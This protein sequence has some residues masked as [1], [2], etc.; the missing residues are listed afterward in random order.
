MY[1]LVHLF[2]GFSVT[3]L[4]NCFCLQDIRKFFSGSTAVQSKPKQTSSVDTAAKSVV[5][6][7]KTEKST[8]QKTKAASKTTKSVSETAHLRQSNNASNESDDIC[9]IDT[10]S[11]TEDFSCKQSKKN[12]NN[13]D[14][15]ATKRSEVKASVNKE[16]S[17]AASV[18]LQQH[19]S[20]VDKQLSPVSKNKVSG[21]TSR[22]SK[23]KKVKDKTASSR[24]KTTAALKSDDECQQVMLLLL[25][26]FRLIV[27][28][29]IEVFAVIVIVGLGVKE[30][31]IIGRQVLGV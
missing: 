13:N 18:S 25:A 5:A 11:E 14:I 23:S 30:Y 9:I 20:E 29:Y 12:V 2:L 21:G 31:S 6:D 15:K 28:K 4:Y 10:E 24:S 3:W 7:V 22:Q 26:I 19:E 8:Q 17:S 1:S 16:I 27:I